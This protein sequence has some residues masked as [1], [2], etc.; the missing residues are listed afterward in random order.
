MVRK[1]DAW[2]KEHEK[3]RGRV[4]QARAS[5]FL[6]GLGFFAAG[7][8]ATVVGSQVIG[9][10]FLISCIAG[11]VA[12]AYHIQKSWGRT[13]DWANNVVRRY[14][15]LVQLGM[16][17]DLHEGKKKGVSDFS[18]LTSRIVELAGEERPT[19]RD[20]SVQALKRA[21]R[22]LKEQE[23]LAELL[24]EDPDADAALDAAGERIDTELA[25]IR[26]RLAEVYAALLELNAGA[27]EEEVENLEVGLSLLSAELEVKK[28]SPSRRKAKLKMRA[29][30]E[31]KCN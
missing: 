7:A 22:L 27:S 4:W 26:A 13:A 12:N 1:A 15:E 14:K 11:S 23:H 9:G 17:E 3:N 29:P 19:L 20:S 8:I 25:L 31:K 30:K 6:L 21:E 2:L 10:A 16:T 24:A 28:V 5:G 18:R